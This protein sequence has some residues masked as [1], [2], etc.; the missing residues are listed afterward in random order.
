[1]R[2]GLLSINENDALLTNENTV[3]PLPFITNEKKAVSYSWPDEGTTSY[4]K[5]TC[6]DQGS[7]PLH[8]STVS[9]LTSSAYNIHLLKGPSLGIKRSLSSS[10][11]V[12]IVCARS[13]LM[14]VLN[15]ISQP[16]SD[17]F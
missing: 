2:I 15:V 5:E 8:R 6:L 14:A 10:F 12:K 16:L 1:M 9:D 3:I 11:V 17:F 4:P 7:F 13:R